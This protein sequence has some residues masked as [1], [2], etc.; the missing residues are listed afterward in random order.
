MNELYNWFIPSRTDW[1]NAHQDKDVLREMATQFYDKLE[2]LPLLFLLIAAAI[3]ILGAV[4]YYYGVNNLSGRMYKISKWA[5]ALLITVLVSWAITLGAG[6]GLASSELADTNSIIFQ[7][8]IPQIIWTLLVYF[9]ISVLC[10]NVGKTN[11]YRFLAFPN[12]R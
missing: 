5:I 9:L 11:A 8:T 10:C 1:I 4:I 12:N 3:G 7:F 2:S 6:Y